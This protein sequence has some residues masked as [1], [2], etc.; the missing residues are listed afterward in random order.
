M[1]TQ[2]AIQNK[3]T[4]L[5]T[6]ETLKT[7]RPPSLFELFHIEQSTR[8]LHSSQYNKT[9]CG[10]FKTRRAFFSNSAALSAVCVKSCFRHHWWLF[11]S[12]TAFKH[13]LETHVYAILCYSWSRD[14]ATL[15][16]I[17]NLLWIHSIDLLIVDSVGESTWQMVTNQSREIS[18][19]E[20]NLKPNTRWDS[21]KNWQHRVETWDGWAM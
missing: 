8:Q 4:A 2:Y 16:P 21:V 11:V 5:S 7:Q 17:D 10:Y 13:S 14:W 12:A 18:L 15:R 9:V 1:W 3:L 19:Q 6:F 20:Q